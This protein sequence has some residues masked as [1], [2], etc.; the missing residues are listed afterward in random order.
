LSALCNNII[1]RCVDI[2]DADE[3]LSECQSRFRQSG[4]LKAQH[5]RSIEDLVGSVEPTGQNPMDR[6]L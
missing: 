3:A 2:A 1:G 4:G 5:E 6:R